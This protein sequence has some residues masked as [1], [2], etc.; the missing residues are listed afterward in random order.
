MVRIPS[1]RGAAFV[2]ASTLSSLSQAGVR[3]DSLFIFAD[4][5]Y[6]QRFGGWRHRGPACVLGRC[7][8]S[9]LVTGS[10]TRA[11]TA[12]NL[13]A[14]QDLHS[15]TDFRRRR[16]LSVGLFSLQLGAVDSLLRAPKRVVSAREIRQLGFSRYFGVF[17]RGQASRLDSCV[18]HDRAAP[19]SADSRPRTSGSPSI[20]AICM[21]A[22]SKGR[23]ERPARL[24]RPARF[25]AP[26]GCSSGM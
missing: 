16:A 18:Y 4:A 23:S 17:K 2:A 21:C 9:D 8:I 11:E 5:Y 6:L 12:F 20:I 19:C 3:A 25:W 14:F 13:M 26:T 24:V 7:P 1:E 15:Y 10:L 22:S